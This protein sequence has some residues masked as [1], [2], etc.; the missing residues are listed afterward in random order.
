MSYTLIS[1]VNELT[2]ASNGIAYLNRGVFSGWG[3]FG[4]SGAACGCR[5]DI[6]DGNSLSYHGT[7][8]DKEYVT[9]CY[10]DGS[11]VYVMSVYI[12]GGIYAGIHVTAY[13]FDGI[14]W[15]GGTQH[16]D[17]TGTNVYKLHSDGTYVYYVN[18]V[19]PNA[20]KLYALDCV[21]MNQQGSISIDHAG[22]N[23]I[24]KY[25][26]YIV[27]NGSGGGVYTFDGVAFTKIGTDTLAGVGV[28][29]D[30]NFIYSQGYAYTFD[31]TNFHQIAD[32]GG[33][34]MVACDGHHVCNAGS[35]LYINNFD[36]SVFTTD[37]TIATAGTALTMHSSALFMA[38]SGDYPNTAGTVHAYTE[39]N[40]DSL[41]LMETF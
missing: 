5:V 39:A 41:K 13:T 27:V 6:W 12:S 36:G 16:T 35:S 7:L 17:T 29:S 2:S 23:G 26:N 31:G 4:H 10:S 30:G 21:N 19:Y 11:Q 20:L 8:L 40:R 3:V 14:T 24:T 25:R 22:F 1:T 34:G 38:T 32:S 9:D 18:G 15:G 28:C 37:Q 33:P